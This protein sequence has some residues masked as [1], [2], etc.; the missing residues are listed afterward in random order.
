MYIV[1]QNKRSVINL[2]KFERLSVDEKDIVVRNGEKYLLIGSYPD[3][4]E[5]QETFN[6]ILKAMD[7]FGYKTVFLLE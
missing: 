1:T 5:A 6:E 4:K 2:D 7:N 3:E